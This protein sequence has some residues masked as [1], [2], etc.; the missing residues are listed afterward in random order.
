[1]NNKQSFNIDTNGGDEILFTRTGL[2]IA[3]GYDRIVIGQ[4]GPYIEFTDQQICREAFY[5]PDSCRYRL[6]HEA[7]YYHEY[8]T[9]DDAFVMVYYQQRTVAYADYK[10]G[11]WYIAPVDLR[12]ESGEPVVRPEVSLFD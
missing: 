6:G 5:I 12:L 3:S 2:K 9:K 7:V 10:I 11:Y 4:R 1:M 8:R